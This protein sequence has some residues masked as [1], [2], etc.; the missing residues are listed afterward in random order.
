L[1]GEITEVEPGGNLIVEN[2]LGTVFLMNTNS[3]YSGDTIVRRGTLQLSAA[4]PAVG[5]GVA[6]VANN[7]IIVGDSQTGA[8][9]WNVTI[10]MPDGVD[11][12][13]TVHVVDTG[14]S[15]KPEVSLAG[16]AGSRTFELILDT[17]ISLRHTSPGNK[18]LLAGFVSG[19]GGFERTGGTEI[20]QVGNVTNAFSG[21]V[22]ITYGRVNMYLDGTNNAF[23]KGETPV[24][25]NSFGGNVTRGLLTSGS[26][27]F[28]RAIELASGTKSTSQAITI[29][30]T[31]SGTVV[32]SGDMVME[33]PDPVSFSA[34]NNGSVEFSGVISGDSPVIQ[35]AGHTGSGNRICLSNPNNTFIGQLKV[36]AGLFFVGANAPRGGPGALGANTIIDLNYRTGGVNSPGLLA[37]GSYLIGQDIVISNTGFNGQIYLGGAAADCHPVYSGDVINLRT[38]FSPAVRLQS[39]KNSLVTFSGKI[40]GPGD[41]RIQSGW[42]A[43]FTTG[44]GDIEFTNPDNDF[45]GV[46]N[47][48]DGHLWLA[49]T[50]SDGDPGGVFEFGSTTTGAKIGVLT[51]GPAT[52]RRSGS[53]YPHSNANGE[54]TLGGITS[55]ESRFAGDYD[56]TR[57]S[58]Y[59]K[60]YLY[61]TKTAYSRNQMLYSIEI[62]FS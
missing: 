39:G 58:A 29:G 45:T 41:W 12:G 49:A 32:F 11:V 31:D 36:G 19:V 18:G 25:I 52:V 21:D 48:T 3:S 23:G 37:E 16:G 38:N 61:A 54:C 28:S 4:T 15:V 50:G 51:S 57:L 34:A 14:S 13:R 55:H 46:M 26:G 8:N 22:S 9:N 33:T 7:P 53:V 42:P 24:V 47:T 5:R 30:P 40:T 62:L 17:D 6:G 44:S 10:I 43:K 20:L 60:N 27:T 59:H 56:F 35:S 1:A 2:S